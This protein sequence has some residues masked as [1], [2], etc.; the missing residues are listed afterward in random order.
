MTKAPGQTSTNGEL[1]VLPHVISDE[2]TARMPDAPSISEMDPDKL[3]ELYGHLALGDVY[4]EADEGRPIPNFDDPPPE[5]STIK[6][7]YGPAA[8]EDRPPERRKRTPQ[9]RDYWRPYRPTEE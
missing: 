3:I 6:L 9:W 8:V 5:E 4:L 1:H 2:H 7:S